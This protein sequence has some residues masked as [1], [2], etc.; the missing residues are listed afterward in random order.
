MARSDDA[1]PP[2]V[3]QVQ[4]LSA[5]YGRIRVVDGVDLQLAAGQLTVLLGANGAGK[6]SLLGAIAGTVRGGGAIVLDGLPL[7]GLSGER[8]AVRGLAFVPERRGNV[9]SAMTVAENLALGL[10]LCPVARRE[11]VRERVLSLFPILADRM[12]AKAGMLSGGEQQM[13]AIGMALGREPRVLLLDEPSQ[14]LAPV[15]FDLLRD[16]FVQLR[17]QG[18]ALLVAEQNL[19]FGAQI[20]DRYLVISHGELCGAGDGRSLREVDDLVQLYFDVPA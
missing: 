18:L 20:A 17:R 14:G 16:A 15:I 6:S 7:S 1:A 8:R 4:A 5:S 13:L 12:D 2:A 19:A 10:R 11:T 9:F 3:L